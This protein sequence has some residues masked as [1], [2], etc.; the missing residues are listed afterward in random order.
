MI[1]LQIIGNL[2]KDCVVNTVNSKNVINFTVAHTEKYRDSQGNNQ[3]KTTWV[4]CAYWTDK[5]AVAQY[6]TKGKQ[7]YVEG[8]PEA[9]SFQRNDGTPGASLS[10]RVREVQLLGGRGDNSGNS[11]VAPST[12]TAVSMAN[13]NIPSPSEITEP[14]DDLPF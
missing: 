8:Q 6:L 7:V 14:I 9:R 3:E 11:S 2:G 4:D 10:L 5:T 13:S 1:K 12:N